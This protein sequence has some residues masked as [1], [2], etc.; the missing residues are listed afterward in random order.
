MSDANK[1]FLNKF[2]GVL[3]EAMY[4]VIHFFFFSSSQIHTV[5]EREQKVPTQHM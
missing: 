5:A 4:H 3:A 1:M 2:F